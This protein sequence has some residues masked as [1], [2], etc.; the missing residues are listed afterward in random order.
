MFVY[1]HPDH[2]SELDADVPDGDVR[3]VL[4]SD[5]KW[6]LGEINSLHPDVLL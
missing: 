3:T 6:V 2:S 4:Y 1:H 5:G